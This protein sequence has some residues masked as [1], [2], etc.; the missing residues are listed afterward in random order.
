LLLL[1][2]AAAACKREPEAPAPEQKPAASA[3]SEVVIFAA[4]SLR[5]AFTAIAEDFKR[6]RAGAHVTFNFAGTQELRTQLEHGA[7]VD[8]FASADQ[9]HMDELVSAGR[10]SSPVI[11]AQNE[12]VIAVAKDA[13]ATI[14]GLPDLASAERIV[15]GTPEVPIGR[16]TLRLLDRAGPTL[17]A[18]FRAKVEAKVVSRELNVKQVLAK[19]R[20]GEAQAGIVYRTDVS[21]AQEVAVVEIPREINVIASYPIAQV[22]GAAHP[23]LARAFIEFVLSDAGQRTLKGAG[24]L[25]AGPAASAAVR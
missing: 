19:V 4:A 24:F 16:Y 20:L 13:A 7:A 9:R 18:D 8:V 11:F 25:P 21:Q 10:A 3:E 17:G 6:D 1:L 5:D 14:R 22:T 15:I 2:T 23:A 12:P